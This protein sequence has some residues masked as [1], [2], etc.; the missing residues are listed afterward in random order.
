MNLLLEFQYLFPTKFFEMNGI[1]GDLVEMNVPLKRDTKPVKY[2]LYRSNKKYKEKVKAYLDKT[3]DI[4]I[5]KPIKE[6]EWISLMIVQDKK[7]DKVHIYVDLRKLNVLS[8]MI[9]S[10]CHL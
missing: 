6:L 9:L 7:I 1:A 8:Y 4:G 2:R 5:I 3:L 10:P